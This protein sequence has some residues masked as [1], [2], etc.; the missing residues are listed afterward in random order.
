V[1]ARRRSFR[2]SSV[3]LIFLVA[4]C[5][6]LGLG[7]RVVA[8]YHALQWTRHLVERNAQAPRVADARLVGRWAVLT[9]DLLAPHPA[10]WEAARLALDYG[11]KLQPKDAAAARA[12]LASVR[13]A[14][15]RTETSSFRRHGLGSLREEVW[16]AENSL[17]LDT[18][19]TP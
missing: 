14:L 13:E 7:P 10:A 6:G 8:G 16:Q 12:V 9:V 1:P 18:G 5:V 3:L 19:E 4:L 11:R 15:E 2:S 17:L